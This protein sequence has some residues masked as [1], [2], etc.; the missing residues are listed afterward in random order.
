MG[1]GAAVLE[2]ILHSHYPG[3]LALLPALPSVLHSGQ[4]FLLCTQSSDPTVC[5]CGGGGGVCVVV[6]WLCRVCRGGVCAG[7]GARLSQLEAGPAAGGP[8]PLRHVAPLARGH[9]GGGGSPG[10]FPSS[11]EAAGESGGGALDSVLCDVAQPPLCPQ[12]HF[13]AEQG[14]CRGRRPA[15]PSSSCTLQ[16]ECGRRLCLGGLPA[17]GAPAEAASLGAAGGRG[18]LPLLRATLSGQRAGLLHLGCLLP[19]R[20]AATDGDGARPRPR[21]FSR[22]RTA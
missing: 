5:V 11:G 21:S 3:T 22:A 9:A 13:V 14:G 18:R 2:A 20:A 1:Y 7:R 10:I 16:L 8:A 6:V 15:P 19:A 4:Q 17:A 12:E